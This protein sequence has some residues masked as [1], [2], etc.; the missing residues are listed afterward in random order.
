MQDFQSLPKFSSLREIPHNFFINARQVLITHSTS[1]LKNG[2]LSK[3]LKKLEGKKVVLFNTSILQNSSDIIELKN[4]DFNKKYDAIIAIGGGNQ[5][6]IAKL[7]YA[8]SAF[9][10]WK[11]VIKKNELENC[12]VNTSFIVI[13]TLPGSGAESSKAAVLNSSVSKL[14]FTSDIFM[15]DYV[16]YDLDSILNVSN[17]SLLIRL[18]DAISHGFESKNSILS[19]KFSE[20]YS[21]Y[22]VKNGPALINKYIKDDINFLNKTSA[23][24]FCILSFYGGLAQSEVGSGLCHALAHT[25]EKE[26]D[27]PHSECIYLCL[28]ITLQYKRKTSDRKE[29]LELKKALNK[30]YNKLFDSKQ[31]ATHKK[32]LKNLD[33]D[34]YI[35]LAKHDLCWKLERNKIDESQLK[36]I[37]KLKIKNKKWNT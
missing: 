15:P 35:S 33:I 28:F 7:I 27:I 14:I 13:S 3:V 29:E 26:F 12:N 6:D 23:K 32:I 5:I 16:F 34:S 36:K 11:A 21:D 9:K 18:V 24:M 22:V 4:K 30:L 2:A 31:V 37:I 8:K 10:D 17:H 19:N 20:P 25:L 1:A